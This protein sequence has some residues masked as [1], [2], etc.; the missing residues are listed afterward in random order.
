MPTSPTSSLAESP[1]A[2]DSTERAARLKLGIFFAAVVSIALAAIG[3]A[4]PGGDARFAIGWGNA[5]V[6]GDVPSFDGIVPTKHPLTLAIGA[7]FSLPGDEVARF[8][9]EALSIGSFIG[10]G[11]IVYRLAATVA[12]PA[13]GAL[14]CAFVLT[15]PEVTAQALEAGKELPFVALILLGLLL[16][17]QGPRENRFKVLGAL[18]VAGLIRP[19]AWLLAGAFALWILWLGL[20]KGASRAALIAAALAAPLIWMASDLI[21][22]GDPTHSLG[23]EGGKQEAVAEAGYEADINRQ[24]EAF[25]RIGENLERGIELTIGWPLAIAGLIVLVVS[26]APGRRRSSLPFQGWT[27]VAAVVVGFS[28]ASIIVLPFFDQPFAARFFLL[29][30]ILLATLAATSLVNVPRSPVLGAALAVAAVFFVIELPGDLSAAGDSIDNAEVT[31]TEASR[32]LDLGGEEKV[33]EAARACE[34]RSVISNERREGPFARVSFATAVN[35][36]PDGFELGSD[37]EILGRDRATL[38]LNNPSGGRPE[39]MRGV[40]LGDAK[41]LNRSGNW[42][43]ASDC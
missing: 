4:Y 27:T 5:L 31:R 26:L 40:S 19:E 9:F 41:T 28:I 22:V 10:L 34:K 15:R 30:G 8:V 36:S 42:S 13:A 16:A 17:L 37:G 12:S 33:G 1:G 35:L 18:A 39:Y 23:H 2:A 43:F 3:L 21:L 11:A 24:D 7:L 20:P 29:P 38:V 25:D 14:A 6:H 32:W